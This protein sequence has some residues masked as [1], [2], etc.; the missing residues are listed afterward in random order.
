MGVLVNEL[1]WYNK[2]VLRSFNNWSILVNSTVGEDGITIGSGGYCGVDLSSDYYNGLNASKYRKVN[3]NVEG[4]ITDEYNYRN[5]VDIVVRCKYKSEGSEYSVEGY[6]SLSVTQ[7]NRYKDKIISMEDSD[8]ESCT[9]LVINRSSADIKLTSCSM[10]RSQDINSSQVGESIGFG[11]TLSKVVAYLDG[12]E[13]YYDG[14]ESPDKLWWTEDSDGNFA[15]INV[16]NER[17]VKFERKN[18][19]LLD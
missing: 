14:V 8:L 1:N 16:N 17:L 11:I 19:I 3:I 6:Y 15:G 7:L 12:C 13:I 18:E 4:N 9:V 10:Y 2:N 5:Y